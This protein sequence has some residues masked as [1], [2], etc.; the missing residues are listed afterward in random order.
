MI[1]LRI[2]GVPEHFN[3]PWHLAIENGLFS[4]EDLEVEW[5]TY[6]G[7]TGAMC[8]ALREGDVDVCVIL[9][10]GIIK[11]IIQGNQSKI[12]S[13]YIDTPLIWGVYSGA[14]NDLNH[15]EDIFEK[16]FAISRKGSGSHLMPMVDAM[17][18]GKEIDEN[19]LV[20]I[21]NLEGALSSLENNETD[22]FYW[23]KYTTK[24]YV[25]S[26]KL[27]CLGEFVTPWPCFVLAASDE[28]IKNAPEALSRLI[29]IIQFAAKQFVKMPNSIQL[30]S[31][32]YKQDYKDI[33][34]WFH[35]TEWS[36]ELDV[37]EKMLKN[38]IH[39]LKRASLIEEEYNFDLN[40][41]V[42]LRKEKK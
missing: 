4:K 24:P 33:E 31:E 16:K 27:K 37:S 6:K 42:A 2:G 11:D 40:Q 32:R 7:G 19:N 28:I 26:G 9:T 1:K 18:Q 41:L 34:N 20:V 12:I 14:G 5:I 23:E 25:D 13:G 30:L 8:S 22:V 38:V 35:S 10:E 15:Y 17:I 3:F 21:K 36:T 39:S 29:R